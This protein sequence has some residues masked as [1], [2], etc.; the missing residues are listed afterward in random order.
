LQTDESGN[1]TLKAKQ[2]RTTDSALLV[3]TTSGNLELKCNSTNTG[4]NIKLSGGT[5]IL[6]TTANASSG[7]NLVL[8]INGTPYK[9]PLLN[10]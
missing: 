1:W 10:T 4:G 6:A 7:Q 8:T 9:I 5:G 2:L 3:E